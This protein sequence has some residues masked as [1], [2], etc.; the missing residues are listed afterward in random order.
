MEFISISG[1]VNFEAA[2]FS[3]V[4]VLTNKFENIGIGKGYLSTTYSKI[5]DTQM[6]LA[7]FAECEI[8]DS[9]TY[10]EILLNLSRIIDEESSILLKEDPN[11]SWTSTT[12]FKPR[13]SVIVVQKIHVAAS[14]VTKVP[15]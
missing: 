1:Y 7:I 4:K 8:E 6:E 3:L 10:R 2:K 12:T 15:S 14:S 11:E 13:D 5:T 9:I